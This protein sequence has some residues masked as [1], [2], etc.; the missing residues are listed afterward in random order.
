M[1]LE[2]LILKQLGLTRD[3][4]VRET[5]IFATVN[6]ESD[7]AVPS[8]EIRSAMNALDAKRQVTGIITE[9]GTKWKITPDGLM[10]LAE[11]NL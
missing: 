8:A 4:A 6:V 5:T 7:R 3:F 11:N 2:L 9:D 1:T 10:R